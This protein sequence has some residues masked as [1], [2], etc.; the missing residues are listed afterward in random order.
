MYLCERETTFPKAH[1][2]YITWSE[3]YMQ[4]DELI[5]RDKV[6]KDIKVYALYAIILS[7]L[8]A[9]SITVGSFIAE[10][11]SILTLLILGFYVFII[12]Q[13]VS[14]RKNIED[15]IDSTRKKLIYLFL[16]TSLCSILLIFYSYIAI[17]FFLLPFY[18]LSLLRGIFRFKNNFYNE[19]RFL[20]KLLKF[21]E[22][23]LIIFL[24]I[25]GIINFIHR[26]VSISNSQEKMRQ[27]F[28]EEYRN[29]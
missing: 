22:V 25:V 19:K 12:I 15:N 9:I 20:D 17:F 28:L 24:V 10:S 16:A 18:S 13:S 3:V 14:I 5:P 4:K 8:G 6:N 29:Q 27:E 2:N 23:L 11:F 7:V 1:N 21:L 26:R